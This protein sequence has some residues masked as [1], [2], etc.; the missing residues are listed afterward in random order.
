MKELEKKIEEALKGQSR[1][2]LIWGI[3]QL[4]VRRIGGRDRLDRDTP[5]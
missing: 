2:S 1:H 5:P 4:Y 3:G